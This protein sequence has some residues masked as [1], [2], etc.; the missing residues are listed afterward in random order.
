VIFILMHSNAAGKSVNGKWI[1]IVK[2]TAGEAD[3]RG[4]IQT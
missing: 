2:F 3:Q 4:G 1:S